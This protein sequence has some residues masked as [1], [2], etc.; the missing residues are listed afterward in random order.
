MDGS[1]SVYFTPIVMTGSP[2][3]GRELNISSTHLYNF[4]AVFII[5]MVS[6]GVCE[7]LSAR[8]E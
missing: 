5:G 2:L 4:H 7:D 1:L 8:D 3:S 6:E